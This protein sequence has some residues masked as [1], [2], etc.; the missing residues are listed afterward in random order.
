VTATEAVRPEGPPSGVWLDEGEIS[1]DWA[2]PAG[3]PVRRPRLP[4]SLIYGGVLLVLVLITAAVWGAGGFGQ[5]T[6]LL[7]PVEPGAPISSGPFELVFTEATAQQ[8]RDPNGGDT[9]WE[10]VAIG[11]ARN[12]GDVSMAPFWSGPENLF[13][14]KDPGS[15]LTAEPASVDIGDD[16]DRIG[17]YSRS[18]LTPGLPATGYRIAFT[19]PA[20]FRPGPTIR[21][22]VADLVYEA[23]YLTNDEK[24]W[25]AKMYGSRVDLPLREL[26]AK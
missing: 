22:G 2:P 12:T 13:A 4:G 20:D 5:R 3:D 24:D 16:P 25:N 23:K 8:Q 19:L 1:R 10:V 6:D 7:R 21:L 17:I 26:P 14:I 15:N 18:Q 11:R 9:K